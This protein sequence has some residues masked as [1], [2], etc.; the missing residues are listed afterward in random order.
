MQSSSNGAQAAISKS[1]GIVTVD[2]VS[3][4]D[5]SATGGAT[6][7]A[8]NST[9]ISNTSGWNVTP[10]AGTGANYYWIG[11]AGNWS[12][13]AHWSLSSGGTP[14]SAGCIPGSTNSVFF[15]AGS[16][17]TGS[18]NT[19]TVD[20]STASCNDMTWTNAASTPL[21]NSSSSSNNLKIY[22]SLTMIN[23]MNWSFDGKVYFEATTTG[24][25]LTT[26]NKNFLNEV[27]FDG[28]GG[29]WTLQDAFSCT[30][31]VTYLDYGHLN[32]NNQTLTLYRFTSNNTNTRA[33]TLGS[34]LMIMSSSNNAFYVTFTSAFTF[35]AGTSTLRFTYTSN[36]NAGLY[37]VNSNMNFTFYNVEFTAPAGIGYIY[38]SNNSYSGTFNNVTFYG[39]GNIEAGNNTY[40]NLTFTAGKTYTLPA[41]KTQFILGTFTAVGSSGQFIDILSSSSGTQTTLSKSSGCVV[42]DYLQ[43]RDSWTTGGA[44]FYAGANSVNTSNNSGW[45][46]STPTPLPSPGS[47]SG[48]LSTC[49][50]GSGIVYSIAPISG[51]TNYIWNL[52]AGASITAGLGTNSITVTFGTTSGSISV[53]GSSGSC[54]TS[55]TA[56]INVVVGGSVLSSLSVTAS[57]SDTICQGTAVLFTA[58]PVNGGTSPTYQWHLNN[59]HVGNNTST[60]QNAGLNG[61]DVVF[62]EMSSSLTCVSNSPVASNN[63][64]IVVTS[65]AVAQITT[66][67]PVNICNGS[68]ATL[69]ASAQAGVSYQW[70][71]NGSDIIG[72]NT[73]TFAAAANGDYTVIAS[74]NCGADT[75]LIV[76]VSIGAAPGTIASIT[77]SDTVCSGS[78]SLYTSSSTGATAFVWDVTPAGAANLSNLGSNMTASWSN[79]FAGNATISVYAFN[80]CDTTATMTLNIHVDTTID[81]IYFLGGALSLC[82]GVFSSG[83]SA[84]CSNATGYTW[85]LTPS[86]AGTIS[87]TGSIGT[88]HWDPA[89]TGS[90]VVSVS[91]F[92]NCGTSATL[93][94]TVNI[95]APPTTPTFSVNGNLLTS[96]AAYGY[97]WLLNNNPIIGATAQ[98]YTAL[99]SGYYSVVVRNV[100]GCTDTSTQIYILVTGIENAFGNNRFNV[101]PNP[102]TNDFTITYYIGEESKTTIELFD[103]TGR[104]IS[105]IVNNEIR[106]P[107]DYSIHFNTAELGLSSGMY[108]LR[109]ASG[110]HIY[111]KK[112]IKIE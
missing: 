45:I 65:I 51:A 3:F 71:L 19:V 109:M 23:A 105:V 14:N 6:F 106:H 46:F 12:N 107:G 8:T 29:G 43:L 48:P 25:T 5:I 83:Y 108:L 98:T 95:W 101:M 4:K 16:N 70:Q 27:H 102:F 44:T 91:A 40:N 87:G 26:F 32:T 97:Q 22:G 96:S 77:G 38:N 100:H 86:N 69:N 28:A 41:N 17:F 34:S 50:N 47:I 13:A 15:D 59:A 90:A 56:S 24:K 99:V 10:P 110:E 11:G 36:S 81:Q 2:Y 89:F 67:G 57:P 93:N 62:C 79:I 35:N 1:A 54:A 74:N 66:P 49:S 7:N 33:L 53:Y 78:T 20:V 82:Q 60:Y 63:I 103:Q 112:L 80:A 73:S 111:Y 84:A 68:S 30:G 39:H 75:S 61:G 72:A 58:T 85:T 42:A 88:V 37:L 104:K 18:S 64:T 21:F 76:S 31:S 52:P 94:N 55:P 9:I 92:N